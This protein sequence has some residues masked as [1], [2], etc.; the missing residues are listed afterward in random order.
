MEE[1]IK[2]LYSNFFNDLN[3]DSSSGIVNGVENSRF[4]TFPYIGENYNVSKK[5]ILFVGMDIG[6]DETNGY[7]QSLDERKDSVAKDSDYNPHIAGTYVTALYFLKDHYGWGNIWDKIKDQN[8]MQ[9]ATKTINHVENENPLSFVALT[10]YYKFV[11]KN[12]INRSDNSNR[13]YINKEA[14]TN[15]LI[16]EINILNPK[17]IIFQG[18]LPIGDIIGKLKNKDIE[19]YKALHPS[20]RNKNGRHP[21]KYIESIIKA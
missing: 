18:N 7:I 17:I 14:E 5:K 20:N 16:N 4:A 19:I 3:I 10:N 21:E 6:K 15:L 8:T 9:Q 11:N 13:K 2:I 12:Q 1:K